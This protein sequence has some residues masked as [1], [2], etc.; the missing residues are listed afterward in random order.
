MRPACAVV[1]AGGRSA[2]FGSD[3][4]LAPLQGEPLLAR[5]LRSLC[6]AGFAQ[7]GVAAKELA[8]YAP[9]AEEIG[10]VHQVRVE[11]LPDRNAA[12]TPLSGLAAGL[13]GSRHELVFACAA[14]MPFAVDLSLVD[15]L[16]SSAAGHDAAIPE[17]G[18][19]LQP[20]CA[21]WRKDSCLPVA[22]ELL[23]APR[24]PGP[25]AMLPALRW[26]RLRWDDPRPFLDADTPEALRE[27]ERLP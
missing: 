5:A 14:D 1:L 24:P 27:L 15:A 26:A 13:R 25:R 8:P 22:E 6:G 7:V 23:S 17:G 3:K 21:V 2:R 9:I 18:G 11:L 12:Q 16:L 10:R 20:L 4:A 19:A